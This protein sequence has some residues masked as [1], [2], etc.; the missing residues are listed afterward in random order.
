MSVDYVKMANKLVDEDAAYQ[1]ALAFDQ[2]KAL[3]LSKVS[4]RIDMQGRDASEIESAVLQK[5]QSDPLG[6]I[7]M[8]ECW[9]YQQIEE[10]AGKVRLPVT[11]VKQSA[12]SVQVPPQ[13]EFE[14]DGPACTM[15]PGDPG[16]EECEACQ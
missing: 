8:L 3:V 9:K 10:A 5:I 1:A 15:R 6:F 7:I 14:L 2:H 12:P 4:T 16:F 13:A 11:E